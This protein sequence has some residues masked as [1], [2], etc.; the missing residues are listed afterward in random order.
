[1]HRRVVLRIDDGDCGVADLDGD[2]FTSD[3]DCDDSDSTVYPGATEIPRDGIDQDCD[4][5]D[6]LCDI[7][8]VLDCNGACG[9]SL[10]L[11][12]GYCDDGSNSLYQGTQVDFSCSLNNFDDG[13]CSVSIDLDGD[14]YDETVDCDDSDPA[15]NPGAI[16]IPNDSIDQDCD[17]VDA[18]N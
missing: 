6:P 14:G 8:E 16:D 2:G 11:G 17:G 1:M 10:W 13:D 3:V 12:D 18:R 7:D 5:V 4:G 15:I 9:P